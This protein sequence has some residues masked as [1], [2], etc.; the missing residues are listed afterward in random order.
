MDLIG[1]L[2]AAISTEP[3][4]GWWSWC[5]YFRFA[6]V[7]L[8]VNSL[9]LYHS[10]ILLLSHGLLCVILHSKI[11]ILWCHTWVYKWSS[12]VA[13]LPSVVE[14]GSALQTSVA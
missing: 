1:E 3:G 11:A 8:E 13:V 7:E 9:R 5:S 4:L 2:P 14:S 12:R 6:W 10:S